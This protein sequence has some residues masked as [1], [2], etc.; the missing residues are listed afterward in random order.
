MRMVIGWVEIVVKLA[1][2]FKRFPAGEIVFVKELRVPIGHMLF[3]RALDVLIASPHIANLKL[4]VAVFDFAQDVDSRR[5]GDGRVDSAWCE[6]KR[7][8]EAIRRLNDDTP[9]R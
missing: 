4:A 7:S 1:F 5:R 8:P 3:Q 2:L 9:C 6:G